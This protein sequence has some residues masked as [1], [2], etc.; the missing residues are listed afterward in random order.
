MAKTMVA[1]GL[2][3]ALMVYGQTQ[4]DLNRQVRNAL[5]YSSGGTAAN[6]QIGARRNV[7]TTKLVATDFPG[8]DLAEKIANA[9]ASFGTG[10][11]GTVAIPA[12]AYTYSNTI[13]LPS[14]C[15][16]EGAGFH[17]IATQL[18]YNGPPATPAIAIMNPDMTATV[19][20]NVRDMHISTNSTKCVNDGMLKWNPA[21]AGLNKWQCYDGASYT[22]ATAHL[23][24]ILHGQIDPNVLQDGVHITISNI[25]IDGDAGGVF[26]N[27][28]GFHFGLYLNG[29]EE[30]TIQN[31]SVAQA[32]DG[33]YVGTASNGVL[34]SQITA[35]INRRAGFTYRG[36]SS[37]LC[38]MCLFES[39]QWWGHATDPT[40]YGAGIRLTGEN[41][42]SIGASGGMFVKTYF[43]N[44]WADVMIPS[45]EDGS[46]E[47]DNFN[48]IRGKFYNS[49]WRKCTIPD[50]S[51]VTVSEGSTIWEDCSVSGSFTFGGGHAKVMQL[52]GPGLVKSTLN[53]VTTYELRTWNGDTN[54][55]AR[56]SGPFT[57]DGVRLENVSSA[58]S[59][60]QNIPSGALKFLGSRWNGSSTTPISW[61]S[62]AL[63]DGNGGYFR[64]G[65][66][67]DWFLFRDNGIAQFKQLQ[68]K[69]N[70]PAAAVQPGAGAGATC[71]R[72][73]NS[74]NMVGQ[75]T[76]TTGTGGW[77]AGSQCKITPVLG[78]NLNTWMVLTPGNAAAAAAMNSRQVYVENR[79]DGSQYTPNVVFGLADTAQN[80][81]VWNF[82][83]MQT[84]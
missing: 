75:I 1:S 46:I 7:G 31:V 32:D 67:A 5:P 45:G 23:A 42:G 66:G 38:N 41:T 22:A 68:S 78:S 40:K 17:S 2:L 26:P 56:T 64:I 20:A 61:V 62:Q 37:F 80:T 71:T 70:P 74:S 21:A 30:C 76:M 28:G 43:E 11:C 48:N 82:M 39:N 65:N 47:V 49:T 25:D 13:Y 33:F 44:N 4:I 3:F 29:C 53:G 15:T 50:A 36:V 79:W 52:D 60:D 18:L 63:S 10:K 81:Y 73:V 54:L 27:Q 34:F 24:A 72:D 8:S 77:A 57:D 83:I 12:G 69:T 55:Y 58:T 59:S 35:R 9:F 14:G 51:L 16:L 84:Y 6:S 19:Y